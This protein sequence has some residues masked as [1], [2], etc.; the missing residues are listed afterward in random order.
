[1]YSYDL[2]AL[3][4]DMELTGFLT[5]S[6]PHVDRTRAVVTCALLEGLPFTRLEGRVTYNWTDGDTL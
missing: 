6:V 2:E 1:M 3:S 4:G 5:R